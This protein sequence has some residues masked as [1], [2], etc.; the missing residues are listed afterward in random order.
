MSNILLNNSI[1]QFTLPVACLSALAMPIFAQPVNSQQKKD[2]S[3]AVQYQIGGRLQFDYDYFN[4]VHNQ[5]NSGSGSEIRRG[6]IDFKSVLN[7]NWQAKVQVEVNDRNKDAEFKD[8]YVRYKS[9]KGFDFTIGKAKEPFGLE[10]LESSKYIA[11]IERAM[12]SDA[13]TPSRN[14][15]LGFFGQ[16]DQFTLAGGV[17]TENQ[18]EANQDTYAF[19]GR[20]TYAPRFGEKRFIHLGLAGSYRDFDGHPYQIKKRAEVHLGNKIIESAMTEADKIILLGLES[21]L[22]FGPLSIRSEYMKTAIESTDSGSHASD[23]EYEGY[24]IQADYFLTGESL[25]YK[26]GQFNVFGPKSARNV[27]QLVTR[28]SQI[29]LLDKGTGVEAKNLT[30]GFNHYINPQIRLSAN[31][32]FTDLKGP[33]IEKLATKNANALSFRLQYLF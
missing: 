13:F 26:R 3:E 19:T 7:P 29:E 30:V 4:G 12:I 2:K 1:K 15:G 27:W 10:T 14:Y 21:A 18:T 16:H 32:I 31:Y 8:A 22:V 23:P 24:Y 11:T 17:Y 25:S 28:F 20:V 6:R 33:E 9:D 5:D